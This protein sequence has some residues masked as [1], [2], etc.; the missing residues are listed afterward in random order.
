VGDF[1]FY[2][3]FFGGEVLHFDYTWFRAVGPGFG[4]RPHC[5]IVYMG[6]GTRDQLY[7][8]WVPM[9]D[10]PMSLG[11]LMLLEG[12][13]LQQERLRQYLERDVDTY[14][15]NRRHAADI[16]SGN[17]AWEWDGSLAADPVSIREKLGGRW[18]TTNFLAGDFITFPMH[19]VHASL[20]NPTNRVRL[21]SDSRYQPASLPADERWIGE[22]PIGHSLAG[23]RGRIC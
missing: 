14:C 23:K 3:Q 6:R 18:L 5:D 17:K 8:A 15:T 13:H 21:S 9:G 19:M 4:T 1:E 2:R 11:G 20:D 10:V 16:E 12:S 7:T 22:N